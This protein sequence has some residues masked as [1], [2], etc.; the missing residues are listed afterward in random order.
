MER[1][2]LFKVVIT[3][4]FFFTSFA[5][6][7]Q[8]SKEDLVLI[9]PY[10]MPQDHPIKPFLDHL[11]SSS[12]V[13]FNL[14]TLER[15]GFDKIKPRKFTELIVTK[16]YALP[17]Y[18][19]KLYL[20]TQ[21][22]HKN[23]PE[24]YY[25]MLRA[26]GAKQISKNIKEHHL[27]AMFKVPQKWIYAL[28]ERPKPSKDYYPKYYI[29]VEEDMAILSDHD[30][31][32]LWGSDYV[33]THLLDNLFFLLKKLGLQDCAKPDN[34]PFSSDGRISFIDTQTFG[35]KEIYYEKLT[36]Y[37]SDTNQAYWKA[38]THE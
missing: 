3:F 2:L 25:W 14:K 36:S 16:H 38:I 10:L 27:E 30:N 8:P 23:R 31:Q 28:P 33:S 26:K 35:S 13:I 1:G 11:F 18:V 19:F 5:D 22:Y 15:A 34:I 29:L 4:F 20:D 12:R 7:K 17:G 21:R 6:A 37:L 9:S 32:E 24:Y